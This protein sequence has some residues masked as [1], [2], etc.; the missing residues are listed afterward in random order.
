MLPQDQDFAQ[1]QDQESWGPRDQDQ[2]QDCPTKTKT[3]DQD[4]DLPKKFFNVKI[5]HP[6]FYGQFFAKIWQIFSIF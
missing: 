5:L 4:Q 6:N 1:D 3:Q 2:D